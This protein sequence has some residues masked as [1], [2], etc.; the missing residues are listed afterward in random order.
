MRR[1]RAR[2]WCGNGTIDRH[3]ALIARCSGIAD[4]VRAVDFAGQR[5]L[6]VAVRGGLTTSPGTGLATEASSFGY[7][8]DGIVSVCGTHANQMASAVCFTRWLTDG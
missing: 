1:T 4:V 8:E 5:E 2:A 3:P 6:A 7:C